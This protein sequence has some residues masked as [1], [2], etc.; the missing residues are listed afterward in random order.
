MRADC[1]KLRR[2]G[3]GLLLVHTEIVF[4]HKAL[5]AEMYYTLKFPKYRS[6]PHDV[7]IV[8][9]NLSLCGFG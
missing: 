1:I 8:F 6:R 3:L 9:A 5:L 2:G 4:S 7:G